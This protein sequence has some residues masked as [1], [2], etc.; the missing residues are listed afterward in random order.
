MHAWMDGRI[1]PWEQARIHVRTEAVMNATTV[2]EGLRAYWNRDQRH[3]YVFRVPEHIRRL[4][5][6]ARIMRMPVGLS[7]DTIKDGITALLEADDVREDVHIR[8][9]VYLGE[10][11][12]YGSEPGEIECGAFITATSRPSSADVQTGVSAGVSSWRRVSDS[13][14]PP[15][16]KTGA[17]YQNSRLAVLEARI[18]GYDNAIL[19]DDTGKVTEGPGA[20]IFIVRDGVPI[21]PP[22]T[23]SILESITRATIIELLRRE[24]GLQSVERAVDRTELYAAD[25]AFYCGT[26]WEITPITSVDRLPVGDGTVGSITRRLQAHYFDLVRGERPEYREWLTCVR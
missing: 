24:L 3:L 15:R 21:T 23:S 26:A 19:L 1:V 17:N 22:V 20:C 6:S 11:Q 2:F 5:Q 25:E 4:Q 10:G 9:T 16:V 14:M 7:P 8:V 18:N 13:S 12:Q